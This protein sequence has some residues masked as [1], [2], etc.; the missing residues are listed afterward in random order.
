MTNTTIIG[1]NVD[2][3]K[4]TMCILSTQLR[5]IEPLLG[6]LLYNKI[7]ADIEG[8]TLAGLYLKLFDDFLKPITK[9]ESCANYI[10]ISPYSLT[11]GGLFKNNPENAVAVGVK[12][13]DN[14]SEKYSSMAQM[15]VDRFNKWIS[16]NPLSEYKEKQ[17]EVDVQKI[18]IN[19]SWEFYD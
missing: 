12:E 9:Y 14:L 7:I 19:N 18:N 17:D 6:T 2:V 3:D 5:V 8:N 13:V 16:L 10:A 15:F 11:N 1:G 4:Y